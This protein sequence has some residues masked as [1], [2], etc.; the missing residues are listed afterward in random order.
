MKKIVKKQV[1][2]SLRFRGISEKQRNMKIENA[3]LLTWLRINR[4]IFTSY[5]H[6]YQ[7]FVLIFIVKHINPWLT[8]Y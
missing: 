4:R 5:E 8:E 3:E 1:K 6:S 7:T 2:S